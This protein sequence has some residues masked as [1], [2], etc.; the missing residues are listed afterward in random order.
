MIKKIFAFTLAEIL[1]TLGI[2]G[3]V[4]A[5]TIPT[6]VASYQKKTYVSGLQKF[7]SVFQNGMRKYMADTGC[8]D[9]Y[10][11]GFFEG[12]DNGAAWQANAAVELP[13][14]FKGFKFLQSNS[15]TPS[16]YKG[17]TNLGGTT[18]GYAAGMFPNFYIFEIADGMLV[19]IDDSHTENCDYYYDNTN[20]SKLKDACA[21]VW[22]D[23]NGFKGPNINGRD[24]FWGE[25]GRDGVFYPMGNF[26][27]EKASGFTWRSST[28]CAYGQTTI[29]TN[30]TG[31]GCAARIVEEGWEMSY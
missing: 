20:G 11:T 5:M 19:G 12:M 29:P 3:I 17:P 31:I 13:K 9:L 14:I 30:T 2:I 16:N 23:V 7:M 8:S 26:D 1:I 6:L 18:T 28:G 27:Q 21:S 10:C 22:A 4:A 24:I 15:A 25:L